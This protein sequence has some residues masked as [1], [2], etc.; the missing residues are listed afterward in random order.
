MDGKATIASVDSSN[1]DFKQTKD[2][3][4]QQVNLVALADSQKKQAKK[5]KE[6]A[7][8]RARILKQQ[9]GSNQD[10]ARLSPSFDKEETSRMRSKKQK[11]NRENAQ[12]DLDGKATTAQCVFNLSNILMGVGLLTL[13]YSCKV[14]GTL[15][16]IISIVCLAFITWRT[17]IMIG[18]SLNGDCRPL[19]YFDD[20]P[21]KTPLQPGST[22]A[23]RMRKPISG[24][25]D[26]AR[27]A[28]G[29]VGSFLLACVLYFELFSCVGIFL[30]SMGDHMHTLFPN[31]PKSI[32]MM[33]IALVSG[34]PVILL[35]TARLL[36]YLSMVGTVSTICV[37]CAVVLSYLFEGDITDRIGSTVPDSEPPY[38]ET[39]RID[40]LP[41]AFGLVAY[42]FSGHAIVPSIFCSMRRPQDF[43]KVV[44]ISFS[45]VLLSCLAV[46][47]SGYMM[48]GDFVLD[49]VTLSLEQNS[50][51]EFAMTVLTYLMILTAF[52]K[53]TLTMFPLAI[54]MEEI[55]APCLSTERAVGLVS[56]LIK[57]FLLFAAL[58]VALYVPSFS[59]LCSMVGM[60]C[61][62][63]VSVIFPSAA[64]LRLF[65]PKIGCLESLMYWCFL[66]IGCAIAII[67][68][69]LS[70]G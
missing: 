36:S 25:P 10:G 42:C 21:W 64:Y 41:L 33:G 49:Q 57:V 55:F 51:A 8:Y 58:L 54:G 34:I 15:G 66:L 68:T 23:A 60:I 31:H 37:V 59:F 29:D 30:V 4:R 39:F 20:S 56:I 12:K 11:A 13:P 9:A 5:A 27:E 7:E 22:P 26:I 65:G 38:H 67:G 16:G 18:R 3:L 47:L 69:V 62:M 35:R 44:N 24:F 1:L 70:I 61:T 28:F 45:I 6:A 46:G 17:S 2:D 40:G 43:E 53:L 50:S 63:I 19:S 32:H 52:S 14:A 48:F